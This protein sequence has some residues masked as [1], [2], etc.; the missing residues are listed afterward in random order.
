MQYISATTAHTNR[1]QMS[2]F[3]L[4]EVL[5]VLSILVLLATFLWSG[6]RSY[7]DRQ[8]FSV[9]IVDVKDGLL[10]AR[11]QTIASDSDTVYGFH[12]S[13]TAVALF[14]GSVFVENDPAN[15][16]FDLP[17][18]VSATT[19]FSG[20]TQSVTFARLSGEA[21]AT[22]TLTLYHSRSDSYATITIRA[23]GLIE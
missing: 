21:S 23:T 22:G 20:G 3:T 15:I 1:T 6:M 10:E 14:S 8:A 5:G 16:V 11:Q 9:V 17:Q 19:S 7:A 18:T 2:G 4:I 12:V 13:S